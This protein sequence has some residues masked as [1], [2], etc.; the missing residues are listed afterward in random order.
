MNV[1]VVIPSYNEGARL[2]KTLDS[3]LSTNFNI[4]VVDDGSVDNTNELIANYPIHYISHPINCG[5]GAALKTGTEY[6]AK[7]GSDIVAHFDADGQHRVEDLLK[8]VSHLEKNDL[9]V[10]LGS[11]FIEKT[12]EFPLSK[13]I[14]LHL[15]KAFTNTFVGLNFT[16]PQ[17][18]LRVFNLRVLAQLDW[19]KKDFLHCTEILSLIA[20]HKLK[21]QELPVIVNYGPDLKKTVRPKIS[22]GFRIL[23]HKLM[24]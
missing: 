15:A 12:T 4:I 10:V 8:L 9:D 1:C 5:Q 18:G 22:M 6:A 3:L 21:Y 11:R 16:D 13:K 19:Q 17:N 7:L 23:F 20:K 14:I 2:T 24:D